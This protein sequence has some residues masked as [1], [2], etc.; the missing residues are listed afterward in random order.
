MT[1][2]AQIGGGWQA[3]ES[4]PKD[5]TAILGC[6]EGT[7]PITCHYDERWKEFVFAMTFGDPTRGGC[8]FVT[9]PTHWQPLPKKLKKG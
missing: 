2:K 8:H 5:G 1:K 6:T 9:Y 7:T 4:A 3:I